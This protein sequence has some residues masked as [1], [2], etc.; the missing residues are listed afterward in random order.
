VTGPAAVVRW[1][2]V[3]CAVLALLAIGFGRTATVVAQDASPV[4]AECV[5]PDLPPGTATPED[6]GSPEAEMPAMEEEAEPEASP[7]V[8]E[9]ADEATAAAAAEAAQN[10]A[11]CVNSGDIEGAVALFTPNMIM[12]LA[13]TDNPYDAVAGLE[14]FTLV[15]FQTGDVQT[16]PD[17]GLS[18][19]V[20]YLQSQYQFVQER[21]W[22]VQD[23]EYWKL[24]GF[25]YLPP[26]P[27]GD[28]AVVGVAL[29]S[30][31][32]EYSVTP[33]ASSVAQ[34]EVLIFHAINGGQELHQLVVLKLPE[35]ADPMGLMDGSISDDQ[36][37]FIGA[38]DGIAPGESQD[39]ALIGLP[40]G[41]YTLTCFYPSP[42]GTAHIELGMIASFEVT[43][44]A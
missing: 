41:V 19:D 23:G 12:V 8:G 25:D 11:N 15:D 44:P 40:P 10:I 37:E 39:L 28:T 26:E 18:I 22:L 33:N 38:V 3:G 9:P 29:G 43:A 6:M 21:W 32:N 34:P 7:V 42:D 16:Y 36:I 20:S 27:E 1:L 13:G 4:P 5:A 31:A 17:G 24:D 2:A 14:G 30:A 35:G